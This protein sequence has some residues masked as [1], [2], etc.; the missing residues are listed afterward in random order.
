[1]GIPHICMNFVF[2]LLI[3]RFINTAAPEFKTL[4]NVFIYF[5]V[6]L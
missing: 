2:L 3:I 4:K 1:M 6:V 5:V